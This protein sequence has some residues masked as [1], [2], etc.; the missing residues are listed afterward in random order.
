MPCQLSGAIINKM[1][2]S[3]IK[4]KKC[5][6]VTIIEIILVITDP[7]LDQIIKYH[8]PIVP[9]PGIPIKKKKKK[10]MVKN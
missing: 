10:K 1:I 3:I 5:Q 4:F 6:I 7:Y 9:E 2:T 8:I